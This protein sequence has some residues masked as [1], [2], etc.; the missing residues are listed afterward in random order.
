MKRNKDADDNSQKL[1]APILGSHSRR[2][3]K[4]VI[5]VSPTLSISKIAVD[6]LRN[7][8]GC[9]TGETPALIVA[10][11]G[12]KINCD[13]IVIGNEKR[14]PL[15]HGKGVQH[16]VAPLRPDGYV[17][18]TVSVDGHKVVVVAGNEEVGDK[19]AIHHLIR[20]LEVGN[21]QISFGDYNIVVNPFFKTRTVLLATANRLDSSPH[22]NNNKI[23]PSRLHKQGL[24]SS[25]LKRY[26]YEGWSAEKLDKYVKQLDFY[27][28]N[29]LHLS[30]EHYSYA[31]GS[32]CFVTRRQHREKIV[33][34]LKLAEELGN[35]RVF[36]IWGGT[37]FHHKPDTV[38]ADWDDPLCDTRPWFSCFAKNQLCWN[39]PKG[40]NFIQRHLQYLSGY[41]PFVD[42]IVSHFIDP[43]GCARQCCTIATAMEIMNYEYGLFRKGNANMGASFNVWPLTSSAYGYRKND[44]A[45]LYIKEPRSWSGTF[46]WNNF[47]KHI[48]LLDPDIMVANR[49]Y[50][51]EIAEL[52]RRWKR[53][54]DL[55]TWYNCD[56]ETF[57]SLHVQ[58]EQMGRE[59]GN[60]P[61][62][63]SEQVDRIMIGSCAHGLNSATLYIGAALLWNP[64]RDPFEILKEFCNLVFGPKIAEAMYMG[65]HAIAR[66]RNH[67]V[68]G[69]SAFDYNYL[70]A[71]TAEPK[72]DYRL[73][74]EAS[75]ALTPVVE[76]TGW[77]SKIPMAVDRAELIEDL[78]EH[79]EM[80]RQYAEFRIA[81]ERLAG[82]ARFTK[83]DVAAL[84]VVEKLKNSGG[85]IEWRKYN[86][87]VTALQGS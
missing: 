43:G 56:Q 48:G 28:F 50:D 7:Y 40:R 5:F 23:V 30:D 46:T 63:A 27:G 76:D 70:G 55:W 8:I 32:A 84:P 66:I 54:Y 65:Y 82:K 2:S 49:R 87:I 60:L 80:V 6:Y 15:A 39:D 4:C 37:I 44:Y 14:N 75:E 64:K 47:T 35:Q 11:G 31:H 74:S 24:S 18:K 77:V 51:P 68:D 58:A 1:E 79:L 36:S 57:G 33:R 41:A 10:G 21:G 62:E 42:H 19:Y 26:H 72:E 34:M 16:L 9:V 38:I 86:A 17:L 20:E 69:D 61:A 59:F 73:A 45:G 71:G 81:F 52:C 25:V 3:Q 29:A 85:M 12:E 22:P 13:C 83:E 67:D 53:G 78:K